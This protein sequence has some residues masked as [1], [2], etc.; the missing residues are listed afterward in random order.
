MRKYSVEQLKDLLDGRLSI[1]EESGLAY[2]IER[3]PSLLNRLEL[4]SGSGAWPL[5]GAPKPD[6]VS[7]PTLESAIERVVAE[8]RIER[9]VDD[10]LASGAGGESLA[11]ADCVVPGI[12]IVREIGRGGMGVVYE[13]WDEHVGRKVAVKQLLPMRGTGTEAGERLLQEARA[14][15]SLQHPKIVSIYAVHLQNDMP[16]LVQQF[17]EGETL[18]DRINSKRWLSWQECVDFA[19]QIASGLEAAHEAGI[20][21]RDL[22][23]DNILIETS[24]NVV[25]IADF[26]IAKQGTG[27]GLTAN[28]KIAGTPAYMS[29]EQTAGEPL[30]ARSDLFS[31]GSVLFAAVTGMPPFGMDDPFLV[32][33]RIRTQDAK[34]LNDLVPSVPLWLSEIVDGLLSKDRSERIASASELS[35]ALQLQVNP[36]PTA[37]RMLNTRTRLPLAFGTVS[38]CV[39]SFLALLIAK[40]SG[41]DD[42]PQKIPIISE[43]IGTAESVKNPSDVFVPSKSIWIRRNSSEYDSLTDAIESAIDGDIIEIG[44]H[45]ECEPVTIRG[46]KLTLRGTA[47]ERPVLHSSS[48]SIGGRNS[49]AYFIRTESD[50]TLEGIEIDWQTAM[51]V[52]FFDEKKMNAVVGAAPGTRTVIDHCKIVRSAGGVCLATGGHLEMRHT[53]IEGAAIAF[54]WL[55]QHTQVVIEDSVLDCRLGVAIIY[56]LSNVAVYSRSNL[57]LRHCTVRAD[58]AFSAMLSK[59]PDEPVSI[60]VEDCI[61]DSKH[62]FTLMSLSTLVREQI[63]SNSIP[64]LRSCLEWSETRCIYNSACEHLITRRIKN[65]DRPMRTEVSSLEQW[66]AL[67]STKL[68]DATDSDF[69]IAAKMTRE[70]ARTFSGLREEYRFESI[71]AGPLPPWTEQIGPRI[72]QASLHSNIKPSPGALQ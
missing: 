6:D 72:E 15:G 54:A 2:A 17:V 23:P 57:K 30:D 9:I 60:Q 46:K 29:P 31:L 68:A 20:V 56:P 69:P 40:R 37:N 62:T 65:V 48:S 39:V 50:L 12:R 36:R 71:S 13:G 61:F 24:T 26:G 1:E 3:D 45:L 5:G 38:I 21:H 11:A 27:A 14:A 22:K 70:P 58:D 55:G 7:S 16:V 25:R 42:R 59:R 51:L 47:K 32:M 64:T 4:L 52:P 67:R 63:E 33:D 66:L 19:K 8:S 41:R 34:S 18:Q 53:L 43:S 44:S 28:G 10:R 49:E 35:K